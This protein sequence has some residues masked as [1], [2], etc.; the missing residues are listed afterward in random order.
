VAF[1]PQ[2]RAHT[3][4]LA[5]RVSHIKGALKLHIRGFSARLTSRQHFGVV[6]R[7][8]EKTPM[9]IA[10]KL[11]LLAMLAIAAAAFAAPSAF[12][13]TSTEPEAHNQTPRLIVQQEVH[14]ANDTNCPLVTPSPP[15][16]PPALPPTTAGGGCRAHIASVGSVVLSSHD[17][18]GTE[19]VLSS[20]GGV[21]LDM[22]IDVA[23][24]GYLTHQEFTGDPSTCVV[25]P[26]GQ[27]T[28]P[29]T[30][31]GR[32]WSLFAF[33][34]EVA[35]STVRERA[36]TLFCIEPIIGGGPPTHCEVTV[37]FSQ[38]TTHRYRFT[39]VNV[40]GH[41]PAGTQRCELDGVFDV[42]GTP[43]TSGENLAEQNIEI[44]HT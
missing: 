24:E 19:A 15:V 40:A 25:K 32:I 18:T 5:I 41:A 37:P 42:E 43:G 38:P 4:A 20:C 12:A 3:R 17:A 22:R 10:R 28:P 31:E 29:G 13:Q 39:A 7:S 21:E 26:C 36:T 44:R 34:S 30:S 14:A 8:R 33:E 9:R 23:G 27:L 2:R 1:A 35:G 16:A 6:G 11:T